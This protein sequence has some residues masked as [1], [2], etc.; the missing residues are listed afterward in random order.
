MF[1]KEERRVRNC[2]QTK[3]EVVK[4]VNGQILPD[5]DGVR[6]MWENYFEQ[7]LNVEDLK[8]NEQ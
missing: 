8:K 2:E 1:W 6:R 5:G 3:D 7:I 4:D